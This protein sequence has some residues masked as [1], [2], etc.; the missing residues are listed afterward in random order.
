MTQPRLYR[1]RQ[2][3]M[4]AGVAGGLAEYFGVDVSLVRLIWVLAVLWGGSGLL[5]YIIAWIIIPERNQGEKANNYILIEDED[6]RQEK[7]RQI[8]GGILLILIGVALLMG[9]LFSW[10][11]FRDFLPFFLIGLG[12]LILFGGIKRG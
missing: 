9:A 3:R 5:A 7:T 6:N 1:S 2:N 10:H 4:I 12:I 8:T 11:V